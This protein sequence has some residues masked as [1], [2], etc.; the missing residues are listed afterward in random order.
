MNEFWSKT[1][2][3]YNGI[4]PDTKAKY[5]KK[6]KKRTKETSKPKKVV[7]PLKNDEGTRSQARQ[8][9]FYPWGPQGGRREATPKS[10][11]LTFILVT[12]DL[13]TRAHTQAHM[14]THT[15]KKIKDNLKNK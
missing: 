10:Y 7:Y 15:Q 13:C 9:E 6:K 5:L 3:I 14:C 8:P 11:P 12:R 1:I 4:D 2:N